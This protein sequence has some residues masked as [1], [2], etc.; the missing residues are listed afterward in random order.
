[1]LANKLNLFGREQLLFLFRMREKAREAVVRRIL[2]MM[3]KEE[4][5]VFWVVEM[6]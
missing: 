6:T 3:K 4:S 2:M 1:M 5:V